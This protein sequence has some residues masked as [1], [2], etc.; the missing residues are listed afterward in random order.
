MN[1]SISSGSREHCNS[2]SSS[3]CCVNDMERF[4]TRDHIV[5]M[6]RKRKY[7]LRSSPD[8][9]TGAEGSPSQPSS[10]SAL[11]VQAHEAT[12]I[13]D[14][15]DLAEALTAHDHGGGKG[16]LIQWQAEGLP[17]G[18]EVWVDRYASALGDTMCI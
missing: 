6:S 18:Q 5:S 11:F 1:S 3:T 12:I 13:R 2:T 14:R 9:T 16:G 15:P 10:S 4:V 7:T 8:Y 17:D